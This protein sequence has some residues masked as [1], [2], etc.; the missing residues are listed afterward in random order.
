MDRES[1][2][3]SLVDASPSTWHRFLKCRKAVVLCKPFKT[4][5]QPLDFSDGVTREMLHCNIFW[6]S[7]LLYPNW[8]YFPFLIVR[9]L[10]TCRCHFVKIRKRH[11]SCCLLFHF[12]DN[13]SAW[14]NQ[15][16]IIPEFISLVFGSTQ[17]RCRSH[18][19]SCDKWVSGKLSCCGTLCSSLSVKTTQH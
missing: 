8:L 9:Y 12:R 3:V 14:L 10:G 6:F 7:Y 19:S 5:E 2:W 15:Q 16:E 13:F 18:R 4:E 11:A 17:Q 1:L